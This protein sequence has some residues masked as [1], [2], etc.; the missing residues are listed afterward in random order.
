MQFGD[1]SGKNVP[2]D[3]RRDIDRMIHSDV[4]ILDDQKA[5]AMV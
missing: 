1:M 4:R 5:P 2:I 3:C